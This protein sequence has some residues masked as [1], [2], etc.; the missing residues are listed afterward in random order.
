MV[1]EREKR[2]EG[3]EDTERE[4]ENEWESLQK[5]KEYKKKKWF[6]CFWSEAQALVPTFGPRICGPCKCTIQSKIFVKLANISNLCL[7]WSSPCSCFNPIMNGVA[8]FSRR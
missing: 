4:R 1:K 6:I 5:G 3:V 2:R 7:L 8:D